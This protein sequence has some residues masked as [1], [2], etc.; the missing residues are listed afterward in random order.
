MSR[1][2]RYL[3][4]KEHVAAVKG[5]YIH[6]LVYACV[7]SGLIAVNLA[8]KSD[9]WVQWPLLGWGIGV[10]G[11][12]IGVFMPFRLFS[13]DWEERKIQEQLT[14]SEQPLNPNGETHV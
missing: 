9:W 11:H 5:F 1:D 3:K 7:I 13:R 14:K 10:T 2:P 12:A 6:L 4:A 8:T